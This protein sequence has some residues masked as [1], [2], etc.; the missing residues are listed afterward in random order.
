MTTG[1]GYSA[2]ALALAAAGCG[3]GSPS[4]TDCRG[5]LD[6][7]GIVWESGPESEGV[8]DPVT[9]VPPIGGIGYRFLGEAEPREGLFMDCALAVALDDV[10]PVLADRDV[11]ELSDLGVYNYRCIGGGE[12]PACP[13]GVSMHAYALAIDVAGYTTSDG[14]FHSVETDWVIDPDGE[15]TCDAP[16]EPG[17]DT[18]LHEIICAQKAA[19]VWNIV[20]T[21]N[22]NADH[23][24]HFHVDLTPDGDFIE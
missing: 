1:K 9:V 4:D 5:Q 15:P 8:A 23:R 20:L 14:A 12:P 21:P 17:S 3:G 7:R 16:T 13:N 19:A 22:Y 24:N 2:A 10:A 11:V 18:F 6:D